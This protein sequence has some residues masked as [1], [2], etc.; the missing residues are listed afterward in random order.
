MTI[1]TKYAAGNLIRENKNRRWKIFAF[2]LFVAIV[3]AATST[4]I[5]AAAP[6]LPGDTWDLRNFVTTVA[7]RDGNNNLVTD[8]KFYYNESYTFRI[9]FS[10]RLGPNG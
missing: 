7:I 9:S 6:P 4:L 10:E 2:C 8:G 3:A 5:L 1:N